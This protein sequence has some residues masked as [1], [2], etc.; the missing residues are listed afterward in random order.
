MRTRRSHRAGRQ[1][2][3]ARQPLRAHQR[4][5]RARR[6]P[7]PFGLE[8][9]GAA[10]FCLLAV[11][12]ST[13]YFLV[14]QHA[15]WGEPAEHGHVVRTWPTGHS[16]SEGR[17]SCE[18]IAV[19]VLVVDPRPGLPDVAVSRGCDAYDVGQHVSMQRRRD[20]PAVAYLE[21]LPLQWLP[22]VGLVG[23][24]LMFMVCVLMIVTTQGRERRRWARRQ[25][26]LAD[27]GDA[28]VA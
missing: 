19:Q 8:V 21:P 3:R 12:L 1:S 17:T 28:E 16:R 20:H 18:E 26:R 15:Y 5:S 9:S 4:R 13:G 27:P 22:L 23:Y 7:G 25:R 10:L 11:P 14:A 6:R 24:V 2:R